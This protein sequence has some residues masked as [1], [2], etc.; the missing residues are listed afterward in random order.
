MKEECRYLLQAMK[1]SGGEKRIF[2]EG[3]TETQRKRG[4]H[5]ECAIE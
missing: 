1:R 2:E 5:K 3:M 4:R